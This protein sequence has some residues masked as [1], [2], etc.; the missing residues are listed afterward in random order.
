MR[1]Q[2]FCKLRLGAAAGLLCLLAAGC[3]TVSAYKVEYLAAPRYAPTDWRS[4]EILQ[5][6]PEKPCEKLGEVVAN[7]SVDPSPPVSKI[8]TVIRRR[9]AEL[10]ATAVVLIKDKVEVAGSWLGG[11]A[12]APVVTPIHSRVIV[13]VAVRCQ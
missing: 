8:E 10:G 5:A 11:P 7:V 4:V 3:G 13:G 12:W 1:F 6:M 9:A 2:A